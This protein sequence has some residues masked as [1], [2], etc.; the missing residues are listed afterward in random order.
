MRLDATREE[1]EA[2]TKAGFELK[3]RRPLSRKDFREQE[4][5]RKTES[6][7]RLRDELI[8]ELGGQCACCDTKEDLQLDHIRASDKEYTCTEI[9]RMNKGTKI[10]YYRRKAKEGKIQVLCKPCN[11]NKGTGPRCTCKE[12]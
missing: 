8:E 4:R 6:Y 7:F 11:R 1:V 2:M 3:K 10:A 12:E 9:I 5:Q